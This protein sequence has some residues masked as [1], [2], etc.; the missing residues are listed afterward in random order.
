L[1]GYFKT[2]KTALKAG[3]NYLDLT[4]KGER[5]AQKTLDEEFRRKGLVC[6]QDMGAAPSLANIM[7]AYLMDKLDRTETI[8]FKLSSID[9]V[10]PEEHTRLLYYMIFFSDLMYLFS[11]PTYFYEEGEIKELEPRA[12]KETFIFEEP[13]GVQKIAG[14]AHSK[15]VCLSK[16]F[17]DK[18]IKRITYKGNFG[19]DLEKKVIFLRDL[20]FGNRNPIDFRGQKVVP[21]DVLQT[22]LSNLPLER[23]KEP[24]FIIELVAIV[25]GEND[26]TKLEY[27]MRPSLSPDVRK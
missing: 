2:T 7:A 26:G 25:T 4:T 23:K 11:N 24:K 16:P 5:D 15:P 27:R 12:R 22:M 20:G 19:D 1:C 17:P 18:S 10:P 21:F 14:E 6:V 8:D 13:I 3:T 9:L